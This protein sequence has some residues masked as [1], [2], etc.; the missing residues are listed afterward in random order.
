[1]KAFCLVIFHLSLSEL[2]GR[3]KEVEEF[4]RILEYNKFHRGTIC[5]IISIEGEAGV[6]KSRLLE[7][8]LDILE[9]KNFR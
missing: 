8:F 4:I 7:E 3:S 5:N 9:E 2:T 6:G 1:M